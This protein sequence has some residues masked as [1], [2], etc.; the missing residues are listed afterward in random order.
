VIGIDHARG[1][2]CARCWTWSES[3]GADAEHPILDER[4][5]AVLRAR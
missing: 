2:N 4:C 5:V 1:A 3:V